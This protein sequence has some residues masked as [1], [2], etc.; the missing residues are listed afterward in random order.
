MQAG[1]RGYRTSSRA[2]ATPSTTCPLPSMQ[3]SAM[4]L[5][6]WT[7]IRLRVSLCRRS[8]IAL[9]YG[10]RR[11]YQWSLGY[12]SEVCDVGVVLCVSDLARGLGACCYHERSR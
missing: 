4:T 8:A 1:L 11:F 7:A 9:Q 10:T 6:T 2:V 3:W 5:L 12:E